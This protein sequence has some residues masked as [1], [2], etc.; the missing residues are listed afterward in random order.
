MS[1][2]S[3]DAICTGQ[4]TPFAC[5]YLQSAIYSI[6]AATLHY[7]PLHCSLLTEQATLSSSVLH[8]SHQCQTL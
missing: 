3:F 4:R 8:K 1:Q 6:C 5:H 7:P 2:H